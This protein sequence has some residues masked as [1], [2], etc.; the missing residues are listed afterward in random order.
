MGEKLTVFCIDNI[1]LESM[2]HW[3]SDDLAKFGVDVGVY[4]K[5]AKCSRNFDFWLCKQQVIAANSPG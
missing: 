1:S 4:E 3:L 2:V 5:Y